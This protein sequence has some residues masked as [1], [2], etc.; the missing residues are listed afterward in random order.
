MNT[1][2]QCEVGATI[3]VSIG[4]EPVLLRRIPGYYNYDSDACRCGA[5]AGIGIPWDG[6]WHGD[7]CA[8]KAIIATGH[9]FEVV[10]ATKAV[11]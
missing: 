3:R 2:P 5:C 11:P 10:A 6:M 4:G 8:H 1:E 7:S 9:V